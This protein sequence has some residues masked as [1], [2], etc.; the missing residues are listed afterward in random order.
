MCSLRIDLKLMLFLIDL[1]VCMC[2]CVIFVCKYRP[3]I[4]I[5][6]LPLSCPTLS[7]DIASLNELDSQ[8]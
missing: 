5:V 1:S 6:Y 8:L 4:N 3:D 7:F 2:V